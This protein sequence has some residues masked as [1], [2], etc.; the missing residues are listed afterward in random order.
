[1]FDNNESSTPK[2]DL[3]TLT[4]PEEEARATSLSTILS[5]QVE[6]AKREYPKPPRPIFTNWGGISPLTWDSY[7][8]VKE[9]Q[10][11]LLVNYS[12]HTVKLEGAPARMFL[13]LMHDDRAS[14]F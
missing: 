1:M 5:S 11:L 10:P 7:Q 3:A 2:T 4:I 6:M 13:K 14:W 12:G 9:P 8:V